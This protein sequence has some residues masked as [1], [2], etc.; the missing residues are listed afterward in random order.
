MD[1][2]RAAIQGIPNVPERCI[3]AK[4]KAAKMEFWNKIRKSRF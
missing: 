1:C 4:V 2:S 3:A